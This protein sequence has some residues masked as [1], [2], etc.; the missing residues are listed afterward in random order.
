[1]KELW[2]SSTEDPI[3]LDTKFLIKPL[4]S[5]EKYSVVNLGLVVNVTRLDEFDIYRV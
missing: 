1:M 5:Q 3:A 2:V 4:V